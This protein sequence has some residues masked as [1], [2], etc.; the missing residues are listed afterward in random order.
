MIR[1]LAH[2][3]HPEHPS[4]TPATQDAAQALTPAILA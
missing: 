2:T 3:K 4:R 1:Y